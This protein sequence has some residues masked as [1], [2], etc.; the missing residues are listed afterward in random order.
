MCC[1][2]KGGE[3]Y[4]RDAIASILSGC[5][6]RTCR[7]VDIGANNGWMTAYMLFLGAHVTAV[8][9]QTDLADALRDSG[10][11]NCWSPRLQDLNAFACAHVRRG[12]G[13]PR[14]RDIESPGIDRNYD[15]CMAPRSPSSG[16]RLGGGVPSKIRRRLVEVR[17]MR[18]ENVLLHGATTGFGA[19]GESGALTGTQRSSTYPPPAV[20]DRGERAAP[21]IDLLKIDGD[22]PERGLLD[23]V[24]M[25]IRERNL[26]VDT[27][28]IEHVPA[29]SALGPKT[30]LDG[31]GEGGG[32]GGG[33]EG[34]GGAGCSCSAPRCYGLRCAAPRCYALRRSAACRTA[35]FAY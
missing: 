12:R 28:T 14:P 33:G 20:D 23:T 34:G 30:I 15:A 25:L 19:S 5:H 11:L 32:D 29:F 10:T 35:R 26:T 24:E 4:V 31:G 13:D 9:P 6:A 8:E 27:I 21:H 18:L 2:L 22:G 1:H 3:P 17:G 7:A 16:F